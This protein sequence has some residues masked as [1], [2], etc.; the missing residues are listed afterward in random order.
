MDRIIDAAWGQYKVVFQL[1]RATGM[2][3]GELFGL[4]VEDPESAGGK[5]CFN[6]WSCFGAIFAMTM[7]HC[8][9][10]NA[11]KNLVLSYWARSQTAT[12]S[13]GC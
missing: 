1:A 12:H 2:R 9:C 3:S 8:S 6:D 5:T 10:C 4:Q 7:K 11:K 13:V